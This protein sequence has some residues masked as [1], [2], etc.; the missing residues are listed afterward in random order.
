[1]Q[2][3]QKIKGAQIE[4]SPNC[5]YTVLSLHAGMCLKQEDTVA[6]GVILTVNTV[7]AEGLDASALAHR[8]NTEQQLTATNRPHGAGCG[9]ACPNSGRVGGGRI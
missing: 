5:L 1:M 7:M 3:K 6:T 8:P 2:A 4:K 9:C